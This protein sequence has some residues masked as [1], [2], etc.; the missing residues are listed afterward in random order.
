M[1]LP[2]GAIYPVKGLAGVVNIAFVCMLLLKMQRN[3]LMLLPNV[4]VMTKL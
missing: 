3:L 2:S 4:K 1:D